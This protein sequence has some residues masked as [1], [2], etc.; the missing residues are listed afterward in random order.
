[1][2]IKGKGRTRGRRTV[3]APPR[4]QIVIRK[5][6][7]WR[8][9][10]V[11]LVIGLLA[12]AG[13]VAGIFAAMHARNVSTRKDREK[14]AIT[15]Y[16][17]QFRAHLPAD[18]TPVPPDAIVIFSSVQD[19]LDNFKDLTAAQAKRKGQDVAAMATRSADGLEKVAIGR[20]IPDEFAADRAQLNEAQF[21]I[22]QSYRLYEPVGR[23][24]Q[25]AATA[26]AEGKQALL[27][28]ARTLINRA[29]A[30]FDRGYSK[31]V[32]L[33]N[34]LGIPIRTAFQPAPNAP[35]T[36]APTPTASASASPSASPSA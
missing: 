2:A 23:L 30:L 13:I 28:Q 32:R 3:A 1:M 15:A 19:D 26:P 22:A 18:R 20:L 9:R 5:P 25:A 31:I 4:R 6:P 29:G 36:P 7:V 8:R 14:K 33:A 24:I 12:V 16:I 27:D 21:L 10:G 34:R 35:Q 17:N 11:W